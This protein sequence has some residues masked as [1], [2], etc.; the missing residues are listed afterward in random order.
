MG[1]Y[2]ID[3][4]VATSE[5]QPKQVRLVLRKLSETERPLEDYERFVRFTV[6]PLKGQPFEQLRDELSTGYITFQIIKV[7]DV[8]PDILAEKTC[9]YFEL[10]R[11]VTNRSFS[12]QLR[13]YMDALD[14]IVSPRIKKEPTGGKDNVAEI[15][16]PRARRYYEK[17]QRLRGSI[18]PTIRQLIDYTRIM[19]CLYAEIV[20]NDFASIENFDYSSTCLDIRQITGAMKNEEVPS[21]PVPLSPMRK[22]FDTSN[23]YGS[24]SCTLALVII[25]LC[26]IANERVE[27]VRA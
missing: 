8:T 2:D 16:V 26:A 25:I 10:V 3:S 24:G 12:E 21:F 18:G 15:M 20:R 4:A 23:P 11:A 6:S 27:G 7:K 17:A 14:A 19:L 13:I 22:R 5:S 1:H 9:S